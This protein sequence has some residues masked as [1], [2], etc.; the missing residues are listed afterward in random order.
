[1][2]FFN[3]VIPIQDKNILKIENF[4]YKILQKLYHPSTNLYRLA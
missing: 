4:N 1:M 3:S 2:F